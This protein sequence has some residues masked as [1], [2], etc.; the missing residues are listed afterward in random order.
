MTIIHKLSIDLTQQVSPALIDAVQDDCGRALALAL[1]TNGIP[2]QIPRGISA[3]VRYRKSDG[4]GGEYD[5]LPDGTCAWSA[6]DNI[7]T[8]ALAPQVLTAAGETSLSVALTDG[9]NTISTFDIL[10]QVQPG[11]HR[12]ITKSDKYVNVFF[13]SGSALRAI[14]EKIISGKIASIVLLGDS[15]TDGVGGTDYNGSYSESPSTNTKGYC[16]ANAFKI[17]VETRYGIPV[18]NMGMYGTTMSTQTERAL[19]FLKKDDFVIWLTGTNDRN[20]YG[21]YK[22]N[23]RSYLDAVREKCS[24]ILL[25]SSIPSTEEDEDMAAVNMQKMDEIAMCAAAGNVPFLSMYQTF[26]QYCDRRGIDISECFADHVHPTDFGH[27]VMF[28]LLC[29]NLGLPLDP[30]MDYRYSSPW[31]NSLGKDGNERADVLIL[32]ST[33]DYHT[34]PDC[35][36][37]LLS[38]IVPC[39]LMDNYDSGAVCTAVSD[40]TI[41]R[42]EL[43]VG[44]AGRITIG[45]VDLNGVGKECPTF[46]ES[47]TFETTETG[48]VTFQLDME[49]GANQTL[50]FQ[51]TDDTGRL[52]FV[53]IPGNLYIWQSKD[54]QAGSPSVDL[55]LYGKI[56]GR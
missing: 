14:G 9:Q 49:V 50:A 1:H 23:I 51:S 36:M 47:K 19:E 43:Y 12:C 10:L 38:Y 15:I 24:G 41:T 22:K 18:R 21:S 20:G 8:V 44:T 34:D 28:L 53:I 13:D 26:V 42:A 33:G 46:V 3:I 32:D 4:I 5:T 35:Q 16:W 25:V 55:I 37:D 2:W 17:F 31:W 11:L 40:L 29:K 39:V 52:G 48:M 7:L 54:Y 45:T 30:Y 56:Y 6:A 27:Y